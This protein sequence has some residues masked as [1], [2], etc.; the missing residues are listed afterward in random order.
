MKKGTVKFFNTQKHF[1]FIT[2]EESG[3]QI[4]VHQSGLKTAINDNDKVVFDIEESPK[5]LR[6]VNVR[7]DK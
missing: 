5:G 2:V 7:L 3:E 1:G 4:F 6:A